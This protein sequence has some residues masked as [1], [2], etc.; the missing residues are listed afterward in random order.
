P[1]FRGRHRWSAEPAR[2]RRRHTAHLRPPRRDAVLPRRAAPRPPTLHRWPTGHRT[3]RREREHMTRID[4]RTAAKTALSLLLSL[5]LAF[6]LAPMA[7]AQGTSL[8]AAAV[9]G[10]SRR[11]LEALSALL[12]PSEYD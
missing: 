12:D 9:T 4:P 8:V 10:E 6:P 2:H 5:G 3:A 11:S 1:V 7:A